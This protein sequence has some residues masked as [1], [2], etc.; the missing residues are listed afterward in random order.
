MGL[1]Q[2][3]APVAIRAVVFDIGGVLEF[4]PQTGWA[5]RWEEQLG[6]P[7]GGL[8]AR[9]G[10]VWRAGSI[11]SISEAE[12]ERRTGELLGL[13]RAR[14]DAFMADLWAEYL[15][16]LNAELAAYFAG[17][18]PRYKTAILSNSFVG[19]REKEQARY[20]F[21]DLC[22]TIIYSHEEGMQKPEPRFYALACERLGVRPAESLF[23]DDV[24]VCVAAA[25][26][27]GM[28]AILFRD[29]AQAIAD[30]E[31]CLA[32]DGQRP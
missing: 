13:G 9:L 20:G 21:G 8:G 4:T 17:L 19:A 3:E 18:R 14:L 2:G 22:D 23:L 28:R 25:R 12:V 27:C 15:G 10:E 7:P 26:A 1:N 32:T 29:N 31:A 5:G 30:I 24:E 16:T 11:G 6:L